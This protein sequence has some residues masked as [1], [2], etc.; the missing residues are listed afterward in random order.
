MCL[1]LEIKS[2]FSSAIYYIQRILEYTVFCPILSAIVITYSI[3]GSFFHNILFYRRF[4]ISSFI[5]QKYLYNVVLSS[6]FLLVKLKLWLNILFFQF[7]LF[8]SMYILSSL[9]LIPLPASSFLIDI[10]H[11]QS[12]NY[13]SKGIFHDPCSC[14]WRSVCFSFKILS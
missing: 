14:I 13:H 4:T 5:C 3:R 8:A 11:Y 7:N 6:C 1:Q 12:S 10:W 9:S 2:F